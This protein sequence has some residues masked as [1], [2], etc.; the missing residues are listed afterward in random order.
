MECLKYSGSK[1]TVGGGINTEVKSR[2]NDIGN[3]LGGVKKMFS[4][5]AMGINVKRLNEG[6]AVLIAP[7]GAE[8]CSIWQ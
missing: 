1:I 3:V 2:I 7:Y 6:V 4:C 5:R 8:T